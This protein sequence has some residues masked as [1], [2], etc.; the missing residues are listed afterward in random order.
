MQPLLDRDNIDD[1][2]LEKT[3]RTEKSGSAGSK[4]KGWSINNGQP[5]AYHSSLKSLYS[6]L[7]GV[8]II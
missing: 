6:I 5:K 8:D 7:K 3:E 4:S 1:F 2:I